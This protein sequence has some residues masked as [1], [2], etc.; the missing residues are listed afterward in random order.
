MMVRSSKKKSS[1]VPEVMITN[2]TSVEH[3]DDV[4][5]EAARERNS[6]SVSISRLKSNDPLRK[7]IMFIRDKSPFE[8]GRDRNLQLASSKAIIDKALIMDISGGIT[9]VDEYVSLFFSP[10]CVIDEAACN[11]IST[12]QVIEVVVIE[13]EEH[14]ENTICL[15]L[16][17]TKYSLQD[18][19]FSAVPENILQAVSATQLKTEVDTEPVTIFTEQTIT[20]EPNNSDHTDTITIGNA[21]LDEKYLQTIALED[22]DMP[23][24]FKIKENKPL[25]D[26]DEEEEKE[27][28]EKELES[29]SDESFE[30]L[31]DPSLWKTYNADDDD[32]TAWFY[33]NTEKDLPELTEKEKDDEFRKE[34]LAKRSPVFLTNLTDRAGPIGSEIKL[35]CSVAGFETTARWLKDDQLV[36][37][38]S[39]LNT[40]TIDGLHS[41][42]LK[43]IQK[44]DEGIYTIIAKN[45][46]GEVCSSANV[47][48]YEVTIEK[49]E[50]PVII[51]IRDYYHH[52][53]NDLIIE[54]QITFKHSRW[55][56]DILWLKEKEQIV[57]DERIRAT[58]EGNEIFQLNIYNPTIADSGV[59]TC[60]AKNSAGVVSIA[61]EVE[62]TDKVHF[63]H[64]PGMHHAAR[65]ISTEEKL[66][67]KQKIK[68]ADDRTTIGKVIRSQVPMEPYKEESYVIRNS[69]NKLSWAG[70]LNNITAQIGQKVKMIC[71]V[72]GVEAILKWQKNGKM[73]DFCERIKLL[74]SGVIAQIVIKDVLPSDAG[75]YTCTAK[76]N[77]NEIKSTCLLKVIQLATGEMT[78]PTFTK[79]IKD[80]I[81]LFC[82]PWNMLRVEW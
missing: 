29:S 74:N 18:Q 22:L 70:Q 3:N 51:K 28:G 32:D 23:K 71:S 43:D 49:M 13:E 68:L 72:N 57:L 46:G 30:E 7:E 82:R 26:N 42:I 5:R 38:T 1:L 4:S 17:D 75:E 14:S 41:L 79:A 19:Q 65:K 16:D 69:K 52:P 50:I 66:S 25:D 62:F 54:C 27:S 53:L 76:N 40:T 6:R 9:R 56:P 45:R 47:Q 63:I 67:E 39:K 48:V 55:M 20:D 33:K 35:Q 24:E 31:V 2:L 36:E 78:P 11:D 61:H 15:D 44:S 64:L 10:E 81:I 59:Y 34:R 77:Y 60:I 12:Q 8:I 80:F 73:I 58:Y 21:N 37:R